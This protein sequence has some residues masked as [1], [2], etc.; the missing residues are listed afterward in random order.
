MI[1]FPTETEIILIKF[2]IFATKKINKN[3]SDNAINFGFFI[4]ELNINLFL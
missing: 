3:F 1:N 4:S 2:K